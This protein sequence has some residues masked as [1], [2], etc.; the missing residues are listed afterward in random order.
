M[1][2]VN[3]T[4]SY[5]ICATPRT[6]SSLLC[7]LLDSTEVAG[8]PESY[9][10][11]SDEQ[12][13]A[14]RWGLARMPDRTF[15]HSVFI[16]A[17]IAAGRTENGVFAARVMW[18]TLDE[19]IERLGAVYPDSTGAD[20]DLLNRAFGRTSFV[21]LRREDVLAQAV[22]WLRAEQV[23]IWFETDQTPRR[24]AKQAPQFDFD[25]IHELVGTINEHDEAWRQWFTSVGVQPHQVWYADLDVDPVGVIRGILEF[26][27]LDQ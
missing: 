24:Q 14:S 18:G 27:G 25:Q 8:R 3:P 15:N 21:Y 22:S 6:G 9:F 19:V 2:P 20:L 13:W 26:L 11:K 16:E 1:K 12:Y 10:R 4:D 5:L 17:A 7:G 23:D